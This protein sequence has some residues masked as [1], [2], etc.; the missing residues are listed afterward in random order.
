MSYPEFL[1]LPLVSTQVAPATAALT[2]NLMERTLELA[3]SYLLDGLFSQA[4]AIVSELQLT[5]PEHPL[6]LEKARE[7][8]ELAA[9]SSGVSAVAQPLVQPGMSSV[10][11]GTS[12]APEMEFEYE[13]LE[14]GDEGF[15]FAEKLAEELAEV[16]EIAP[17]DEGAE[18]IDVETVFEQFKAGVAE[19]VSDDDSATHFDLGIAY[20]EMGLLPDARREFQVAMADPRRRCLCWMMIGL[21]YMEEGQP[22]DAIEAFQSGLESP[23]KTPAESVG[24]HYELAMACE[25]G[26]LTDQARLHYEHVFQ[27]EPQY[28]EVGQRLQRLGGPSGDSAD[29]LLMESMDDVNRAFDELIHED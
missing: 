18:M 2:P 5:L 16:A 9:V 14:P 26:G 7:I 23:E 17:I 4:R 27:R 20:K 24:L 13:E 8:E 15:D 3:D 22:R 12:E 21:I 19:Q 25:A 1:S 28:R 6:V 29:D 10:P 11:A